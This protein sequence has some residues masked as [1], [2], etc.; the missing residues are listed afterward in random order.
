MAEATQEGQVHQSEQLDALKNQMGKDLT[1]VIQQLMLTN[2]S[3][4]SF[5]AEFQDANS[6]ILQEVL[7]GNKLG[8][9]AILGDNK[10]ESAESGRWKKLLGHFGWAKKFAERGAKLAKLAK[11]MNVGVICS[12]QEAKIVRKIIGP[13]L[14]IFTPGV[15][16]NDDNNNDQK[17]ICTP[18]ESIKNGA[19]KIIM[20][21][22]LIGKDIEKNLDKVSNSIKA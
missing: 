10:G 11:D 14:L 4:S 16:M 3:D 8:K 13:N 18:L 2:A 12:G 15:R 20:G 21:R 7:E 6:K 5:K 19:N 22:S 1:A 17:R 9:Q